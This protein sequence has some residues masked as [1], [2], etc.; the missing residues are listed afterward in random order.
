VDFGEMITILLRESPT[1]ALAV[2]AIWAMRK[3]YEKRLEDRTF[4]QE[5]RLSEREA[6][7]TRLEELNRLFAEKLDEL[8]QVLGSNTEVLRQIL[9]IRQEEGK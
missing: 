6:Y 8:N 9:V 7:A 5:Q 4:H 1:A 3:E 2:F